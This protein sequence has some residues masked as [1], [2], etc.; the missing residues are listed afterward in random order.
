MGIHLCESNIIYLAIMQKTHQNHG[1]LMSYE[2]SNFDTPTK[3]MN[4]DFYLIMY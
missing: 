3:L 1:Y 4:M 2:L